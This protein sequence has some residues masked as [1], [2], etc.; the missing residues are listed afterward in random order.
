M[1][2]GRGG[3]GGGSCRYQKVV[4][5]SSRL[6]EKRK[7]STTLPGDLGYFQQSI[8]VSGESSR[9]DGGGI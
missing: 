6:Q 4:E 9:S 1:P 3:S 2:W 5:G 8:V 7:S